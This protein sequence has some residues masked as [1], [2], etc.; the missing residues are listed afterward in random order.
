MEH[1]SRKKCGAKLDEEVVVVGGLSLGPTLSV[2]PQY[3]QGPRSAPHPTGPNP[4]PIPIPPP[5]RLG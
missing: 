4:D 2:D 3:G 5:W 1:S